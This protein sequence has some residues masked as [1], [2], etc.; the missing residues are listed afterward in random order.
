MLCV[1]RAGR[2]HVYLGRP[3]FFFFF[4]FFLSVRRLFPCV[5]VWV[6]VGLLG[7][8]V[9][10]HNHSKYP[11][12]R[13]SVANYL[14]PFVRSII[15]PL[16]STRGNQPRKT[17]ATKKPPQPAQDVVAPRA[18]GDDAADQLDLSVSAEPAAHFRVAVQ[19]VQF[20]HRGRHS[21]ACAWALRWRCVGVVWTFSLLE[22][23]EG[24]TLSLIHI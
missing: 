5:C 19:P 16:P 21:G 22:R 13:S 20:A 18:Q 2:C 15:R 3:S 9:F 6:L 10:C 17:E 14:S 4:F 12:V 11:F 1:Q 8:L 23:C 7:W 24:P